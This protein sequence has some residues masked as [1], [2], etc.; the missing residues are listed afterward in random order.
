MVLFTINSQVLLK[1]AA[2]DTIAGVLA[3]SLKHSWRLLTVSHAARI[4]VTNPILFAQGSH[5][6]GC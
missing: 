3:H 1:V 2:T 5:K 4:L 6:C